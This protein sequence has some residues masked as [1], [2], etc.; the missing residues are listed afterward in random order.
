MSWMQKKVKLIVLGVCCMAI[1]VSFNSEVLKSEE[2]GLENLALGKTYSASSAEAKGTPGELSAALAF[3]G[4]ADTRWSSVFK[5]VKDCFIQVDFGK[6]VT[7]NSVAIVECKQWSQVTGF[8][9]EVMKGDTWST[10]YTGKSIIEGKIF[11]DT[12]QTDK[13]RL[14]FDSAEGNSEAFLTVTLFEVGVYF[15]E[16]GP[17]AIAASGWLTFPYDSMSKEVSGDYLYVIGGYHSIDNGCPAWGTANPKDSRFIGDSMGDLLITYQDGSTGSI[18]LIF[19][20]TMWFHTNWSEGGAPFKSD[21]AN[22]DMTNLLKSSLYLNGGFEAQDKCILKIK[23]NNIPIKSIDIIDNTSKLGNPLFDGA[24]LISGDL[25]QTLQGGSISV[26]TKDAFYDTHI[27]DSM[28]AYP[29]TVQTAIQQINRSLLTYES[30]YKDVSAFTYPK[31]Y[32]GVKLNFKGTSLANIATGVV[33]SNVQNLVNRVDE[34]GFMHTT[35]K[36]APSWRYDGFGTWV[37]KANSYYDSFYSRDGA[38]A[39][40]SLNSFGFTAKSESS[41][42]FANKWMLYYPENNL[43]MKG[44]SIP[45]HFSVIVNKPLIYSTVLSKSGWPTRYTA[46]KFGKEFENI[47]NQETD[48]HGLMMLANSSVWK[49]LGAKPE[50]VTDNWTGLKEAANWIVWCF[51]NPEISFAS[52]GLLYAESEA[53]MNDYTLYCNVPCYEGLLSYATMAESIGNTAEA[54]SWR[55]CA[56]VIRQAISST[57][58]SGEKWNVKKFGFMHDPVITMLS[59]FYGYDITMMPELW[60][61]YS[62]N[63]YEDDMVR[64]RESGYFGPAGIG[65]D[66]SMITQNALLLDQMNDASKLVENLTKLSYAPRLPEPFIVPEGITVDVQN[67]VI[68][69]QG[70]LGN[71]VQLADALKCYLLVTGVSPVT[72]NTLKIMPRLPVDWDIN[73][74]NFIVQNTSSS[75]NLSVLYPKEGKQMTKIVLN[76]SSLE[77]VKFRFGPFPLD[78]TTVAAK[79]DGADVQAELIASGD[80]KWAWVSFASDSIQEKTLSLVYSST[81]QLPAWPIWPTQPVATTP[82]SSLVKAIVLT[83]CAAAVLGTGLVFAK[84]YYIKKKVK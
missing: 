51:A 39:I 28:N 6:T 4:K 56:E 52:K 43:T 24:Y 15:D 55:E 33:F 77:T 53:G 78:T 73:I 40:M 11:F 80:S 36:D 21:E 68:R 47:G 16:A 18:P 65:Y 82:K 83:V 61:K 1:C 30:D 42:K 46:A 2:M 29:Q 49:N 79:I 5:D 74:E 38:R 31:D 20:Y 22:T 8:K 7:C 84:K 35:Y 14:L 57:L 9:I 58:T 71:L 60:V 81:D 62:K 19:G 63:S 48:G 32:K 70:D 54:T 41:V 72:D 17:A 69:R 12:V 50:W 25:A 44:V 27:I 23:V 45:G 67:G 10:V 3:D 37:P 66:H 64:I 76:S 75:L 26:N 34:D 59:D 13:L